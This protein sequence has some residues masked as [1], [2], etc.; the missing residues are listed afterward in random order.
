M[1]P[2]VL[3]YLRKIKKFLVENDD[4]KGFLEID[5]N[6]DE[7]LKDVENLSQKNYDVYGFPEITIEQYQEIRKK[8]L[9]SNLLFARFM[10]TGDYGYV[11]LN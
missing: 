1:S 3:I 2:E 6:K 9:K 5:K 10:Y 8:Y 7:F 4:F 11:S